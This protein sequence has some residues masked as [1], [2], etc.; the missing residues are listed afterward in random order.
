MGKRY[1]FIPE[2]INNNNNILK[3]IA[4]MVRQKCRQ[5]PS[6]L[7]P[8]FFIFQTPKDR[9]A[10]LKINGMLA[11][12][13]IFFI[14]VLMKWLKLYFINKGRCDEVIAKIMDNLKIPVPA[15]RRELDPIFSIATP[16]HSTELAT[17]LSKDL[18]FPDEAN[19]H[20]YPQKSTDLENYFRFEPVFCKE[21]RALNEV[22]RKVVDGEKEADKD[23]VAPKS[24]SCGI[25]WL[26]NA[27]SVKPKKKK[28]K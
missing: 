15:Y 27:L 2:K 23:A 16:L 17:R 22:K 6:F 5:M 25:G 8:N 1:E 26:G 14:T 9:F 28:V 24:K 13:I 12:S 21:V 18:I 11:M 4:H 7:C 10:A 3:Q 19:G 20:T